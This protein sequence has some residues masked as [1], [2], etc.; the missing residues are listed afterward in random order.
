M[1]F[2][3]GRI[4]HVSG[5]RFDEYNAILQNSMTHVHRIF[6]FHIFKLKL[7]PRGDHG[8]V[9]DVDS[10]LCV[11]KKEKNE[12]R[13]ELSFWLHNNQMKCQT[14]MKREKNWSNKLRPS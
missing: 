1:E 7:K 11:R 2:P 14:K 5:R 6:N 3:F 4:L 13:E 9:R 8:F 12:N 10:E